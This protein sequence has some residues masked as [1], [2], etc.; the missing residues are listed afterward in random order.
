MF[1]EKR[2]RSKF[3]THILGSIIFPPKIVPFTR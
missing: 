3:N 1:Q 2:D